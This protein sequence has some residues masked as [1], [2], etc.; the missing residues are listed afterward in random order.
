MKWHAHNVIA[1]AVCDL[2]EWHQYRKTRKARG[3]H[4]KTETLE[5]LLVKA[6]FLA[7]LTGPWQG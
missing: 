1:M 2:F 3:R 7:S 6:A 5:A 4:R